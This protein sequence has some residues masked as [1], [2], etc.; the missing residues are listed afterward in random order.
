MNQESDPITGIHFPKHVDFLRHSY[1]PLEL[2]QSVRWVMMTSAPEEDSV[3]I[4]HHI[5]RYSQHFEHSID[6]LV[7]RQPRVETELS[8]FELT[9]KQPNTCTVEQAYGPPS[10]EAWDWLRS[11]GRARQGSSFP[12]RAS[13]EG[14]FT[15]SSC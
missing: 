8:S 11:A 6:A 10:P 15:F 3:T 7:G 13:W 4:H 2:G 1:S 14:Q 12:P 9:Y 5:C